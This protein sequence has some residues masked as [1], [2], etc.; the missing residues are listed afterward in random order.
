MACALQISRRGRRYSVNSKNT[1]RQCKEEEMHFLFLFLSFSF[2]T[3]FH[4]R[5]DQKDRR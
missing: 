1:R 3:F 5:T 4:L 2:D